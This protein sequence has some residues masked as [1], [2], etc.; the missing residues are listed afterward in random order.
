MVE[1][2]YDSRGRVAIF[3]PFNETV[4]GEYDEFAEFYFNRVID[5]NSQ[6][7]R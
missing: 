4:R 2:V 5:F 6:V 3:C 1:K 7:Q